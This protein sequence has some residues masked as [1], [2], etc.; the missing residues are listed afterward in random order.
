MGDL[1]NVSIKPG[2]LKI[3]EHMRSPAKIRTIMNLKPN[4]III[5]LFVKRDLFVTA[6]G[7]PYS[8]PCPQA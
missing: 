6:V 5:R 7:T 8:S 1:H 2:E 3:L 4:K